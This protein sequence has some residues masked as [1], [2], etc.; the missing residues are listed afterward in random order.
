MLS[1]WRLTMAVVTAPPT[2][3]H[4]IGGARF[5]SLTA[6]SRGA[7]DTCVWQ[8]EIDPGTPAT[9]HM[10]TREEVFVVLSGRADVR[11]GEERTEAQPGDAIVVPA[12]TW[13]ELSTAGTEPLRALCCFPVGGQARLQDGSTLVPPWAE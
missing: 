11:L 5:T 12:N 2:P 3:T 10:L 13:F 8:V 1:D 6:P 7:V 9:P 4:E